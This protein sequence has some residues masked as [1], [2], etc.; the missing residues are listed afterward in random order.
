LFLAAG[1]IIIKFGQEQDIR[2]MGGLLS[3][4]WVLGLWFCVAGLAMAGIPPFSGYFSKE[5]IFQSVYASGQIDLLI[6]ALIAAFLTSLYIFRLY[7]LVFA[8][9]YRGE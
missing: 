3:K 7:F 9:P 6:V 5:V 4:E 8:G 1:V 2:K